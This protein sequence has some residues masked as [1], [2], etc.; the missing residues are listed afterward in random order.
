ME[1]T[2]EEML[3]K[4]YSLRA[5][6]SVISEENDK[7]VKYGKEAYE[8]I[9]N[10]VVELSEK[11]MSVGLIGP[12]YNLGRQRV[13]REEQENLRKE[14][15]YPS[16]LAFAKRRGVFQKN[17]MAQFF[18]GG[19]L[20]TWCRDGYTQGDFVAC[21]GLDKYKDNL[22]QL[23]SNRYQKKFFGLI[24]V[25]NKEIASRINTIE[26]IIASYPNWENKAKNIVKEMEQK[27]VP[28]LDKCDA[29]YDVF[30]KNFSILIDERDWQYLDLVIFYLETGRADT[31][32]EALQLVEREVQTQRIIDKIEEAT[33]RICSAIADAARR[34]SGQLSIISA[35]LAV[36][37]S[38]QVAQNEHIIR[39][40]EINNALLSKANTNS[41][42]LMK[43]VAQIKSY[44]KR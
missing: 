34:I 13:E 17:L 2:K 41:Q 42:K 43:D 5:G 6:L 19:L 15:L 44:K 22:K 1:Q 31:M 3:D 24:K 28:I 32:K 40:I 14:G 8:K 30:H 37:T 12:D 7:M 10:S 33:Q 29:L 18:T 9:R 16:S 39:D 21:Y 4:L 20:A 38:L 25:E 36:A 35:Q 26:A 27:V 11:S 23:E